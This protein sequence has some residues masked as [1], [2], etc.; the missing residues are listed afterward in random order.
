MIPEYKLYHGAVLA[1]LVDRST[2]PVSISVRKREGRHLEYIISGAVGIQIRHSTQRLRPWQ[3]SLRQEHVDSL[4]SLNRNSF[5]C[6]LILICHTDGM[7]CVPAEHA[8]QSL[9]IPDGAQSWLRADRPKGKLYRLFGPAGEFASKYPSG[10]E[11]LIC[12]IQRA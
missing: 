8:L 1:E 5:A 9:K 7:V 2:V 12:A 6:F 4:A 11:P 3:F 10:V